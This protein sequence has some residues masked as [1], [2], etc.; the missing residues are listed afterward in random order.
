MSPSQKN[1][2]SV[3]KPRPEFL[4]LGGGI[5]GFAVAKELRKT[6]KEITIIDVD[7]TRVETLRQ[8]GF[9]ALLG[10]ITNPELYNT[11]DMRNLIC[12][13]A[14]SSNDDANTKAVSNF[15]A[16]VPDSVKIIS[17][18]S[19]ILKKEEMMGAGSSYVFVPPLIVSKT[20]TEYL[21]LIETKHIGNR[22]AQW[23]DEHR[24]ITLGIVLHDNPDPDAISSAYALTEI[25]KK[26]DIKAD[27][28]Y[29]GKVGHH[30]N[31]AFINLLAIPMIK[32]SGPEV[33]DQ[34]DSLALVDNSI[35]SVNNSVPADQPIGIIIDH[36]SYGDIEPSADFMD[37]R[38]NVGASAT[39]LTK[40][41]QQMDIPVSKE[42]ATAL[43]FGIR[44]DINDFRRNTTSADFA[45]ASFLH[46]LSDHDL[47]TQVETPSMSVET[48]D[49]LSEAIR[50]R[51]TYGAVLLSN[52]GTIR[53]RDTLP[54]AAD[55]L[56]AMEGVST[57]VVFGIMDDSIYVSARNEDIRVHLGDVMREAFG[58][59][60]GGHPTAAGARIPLGVFSSAKDKQILQKLVE[61]SV[62]KRFLNAIGVD[63]DSENDL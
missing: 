3:K 10:D 9:N 45:A 40:Y 55:Y 31:K 20:I 53:N 12:V 15:K 26:F 63:E 50:N 2:E 1:V 49:I 59:N 47:L 19:D 14:L 43:L 35:P 44:T 46:P 28:L 33:F 27:I 21:D 4:I 6:E 54:Q 58:E 48:L 23:L 30:E 42:L 22:L 36:H 7:K 34:Y 39:I 57:V 17:R 24:G 41:L 8:E 38:T 51:E 32:I 62:V 61:E 13:A 5:I 56:L 11:I 18:A 16:V 60:A 52:V 29:D 37:I 25:T